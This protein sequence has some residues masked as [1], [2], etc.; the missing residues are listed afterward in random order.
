VDANQ[1]QRL[2]TLLAGA[3]AL[4]PEQR[5]AYLREQADDDEGLVREALE[6]LAF[7]ADDDPSRVDEFPATAGGLRA[8]VGQAIGPY[9][10][11][12]VIGEGG[13]GIVFLAEQTQPIARRVALKIIKVGMDTREVIARFES[14]RQALALMSH[15]H[16]ARV[17][18][19]GATDEGRPYFVME[20]IDGVPITRYCRDGALSLEAR[21]RLMAQ[22][23]RGIHHA[24]QR[25]VIH[26]DIKPSNLLVTVED[27][28]PSARIIDFGIAKAIDRRL[29]EHT[30]LTQLGLLL[31]T[32]EYMSP[33]QADLDHQDIDT[34]S[35]VFSL[36]VVLYE[37]LTGRLPLERADLLR[38]GLAGM[39]R[40]LRE[41]EPVP[42]STRFA[43]ELRRRADPD[44]RPLPPTP[45][46][47]A[48]RLRG[49]L[50]W[51][52]LKALERD[53][54]RRYDS[55]GALADELDLF[56]DGK[57]VE[58]GPPSRWYRLRR[59]LRRYRTVV[60]ATALILAALL[61]G[62]A[63]LTTGLIRAHRAEQQ[64]LAAAR[65]AEA[66]RLFEIARNAEL[67]FQSL[68]HL[69]KAIELDDRPEYRR[70]VR[71]TLLR[72]PPL[73][74]L[75]LVS[76]G[77]NAR[78]VN[79]S[80]DGRWL[81]VGWRRRGYLQLYELP[82]GEPVL[83]EGHH[84]ALS[85]LRFTADSQ[86]LVTAA[87]DST[88]RVWSPSEARLLDTWRLEGWPEL[89]LCRG[90]SLLVVGELRRGE[91]TRWWARSLRGDAPMLLGD[92]GL[93]VPEPADAITPAVDP[94]GRWL[95][96]P[97]D[98][99]LWLFD[100]ADLSRGPVR[101][102]GR[103]PRT[104]VG[105]VY[106]PDGARV[107]SY[108]AEGLLRIWDPASALDQPLRSIQSGRN[109][110][111]AGFSRD[112]RWLLASSTAG[113]HVWNLD[114]CTAV[115]PWVLRGSNAYAFDADFHPTL[116]WLLTS[117]TEGM[118]A[119]WNLT[120]W[121]RIDL[122]LPEGMWAAAEFSL[123][124]RW[125]VTASNV[126]AVHAW[127]LEGTR[128]GEPRELGVFPGYVFF[129]V[130]IDD[131]GRMCYLVPCNSYAGSGTITGIPLAGG[132]ARTWSGGTCNLEVSRDGSFIAVGADEGLGQSHVRV[133][134]VAR[135]TSA[136]LAEPD[137]G[138]IGI[139]GF[140]ADDRVVA[141]GQAGLGVWHPDGSGFT[142]LA[143]RPAWARLARDRRTIVYRDRAGT[144][145][146]RVAD[147]SGP[148]ELPPLPI[149]ERLYL[150]E[151]DRTGSQLVGCVLNGEILY[152][153][154]DRGMLHR[155]PGADGMIALIAFDP[156]NRW[157][158]FSQDHNL[159]LL[160]IPA[161][162]LPMD[163]P[164]DRYLAWLQSLTNLRLT[165][166][167]RSDTGYDITGRSVP[168]WLH[169]PRW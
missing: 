61:V 140:L 2:K 113:Y 25:G 30:V 65:Q 95:V 68:V 149:P 12:E 89:L 97:R 17:F 136:D 94:D 83:L 52:T 118:V 143:D 134:D 69:L 80:P 156:H 109:P 38:A 14:E 44:D 73:H 74:R 141:Y 154:L 151:V 165:E 22:V 47:W 106:T 36:G 122:A 102:F 56:L 59:F 37:L 169:P 86:H 127:P 26:R 158:A 4:S 87:L 108:D 42:P 35:D 104:I 112:G 3:L 90:D 91:P 129:N 139:V 148:E 144:L 111:Y 49:D 88:V 8:L 46:T 152:G 62:L 63:G 115:R 128:I 132:E 76:G 11:L 120:G 125:L 130:R 126:G 93:I 9:R 77:H 71:H 155:L 99:Q 13:M 40:A 137:G 72:E 48:A 85:H 54:E 27:G 131:D 60:A 123:D 15:P 145:W 150:M 39:R 160:P 163:L 32:P 34:R 153:D 96:R 147:A 82:D 33:E 138:A 53:R 121:H 58:A 29:T 167:P 50:D 75:P 55:P 45:R 43:S 41:Q 119:A 7:D 10:L 21:L 135:G 6:L 79:F 162:P 84:S 92:D 157:F 107:L 20:Y 116:P 103:H 142:H 1:Y 28:Q 19:A 64:A 66:G 67:P 146:R 57:P 5:H 18:D 124:G 159:T 24:H 164:H 117:H 101:A 114:W 110:V 168:D 51:V 70:R 31:G 16:I 78:L 161:E 23:C 166:N 100:L 133:L 81:A 98:D 105:A